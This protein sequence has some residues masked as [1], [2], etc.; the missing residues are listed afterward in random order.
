[1][2]LT[3]GPQQQCQAAVAL[4]SA[5]H[6]AAGEG[7]ASGVRARVGRLEKKKK[8]GPSPDEQ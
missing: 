5:A 2:R 8:S 4:T 3:G 1:V 6:R 7:G